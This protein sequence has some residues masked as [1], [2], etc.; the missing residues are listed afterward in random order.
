MRLV[1]LVA[2]GSSSE[3][4]Q[5]GLSCRAGGG[6]RLGRFHGQPDNDERIR[7]TAI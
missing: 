5:L 4:E 2:K 1:S 6:R 7:T 3:I